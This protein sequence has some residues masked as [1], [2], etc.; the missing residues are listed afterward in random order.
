VPADCEQA[1]QAAEKSRLFCIL[2]AIRH[3]FPRQL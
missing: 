1:P 2:R 3:Y